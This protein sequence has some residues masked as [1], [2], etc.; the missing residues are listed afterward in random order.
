MGND[1]RSTRGRMA[2]HAGLAA[3]AQVAQHYERA[4]FSILA[5]RWRGQYGGEIDL[6]ISRDGVV[7]FVEVKH[8][9]T[10]ASAAEHLLP[11]QLNRIALSA[12]EF[13]AARPELAATDMRLDL[14]LVD[15]RGVIEIVENAHIFG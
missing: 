10:H 15:Q 6:I 11:K 13:V 9:A 8:S 12:E 1:R 7:V 14:A 3:E 2:H 4:G 5:T